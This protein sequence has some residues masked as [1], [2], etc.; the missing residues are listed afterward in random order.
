MPPG[1]QQLAAQP[2]AVQPRLRR[3]MWAAQRPCLCAACLPPPPR[4]LRRGQL[5]PAQPAQLPAVHSHLLRHRAAWLWRRPARTAAAGGTAGSR[6][7][8]ALGPCPPP[9]AAAPGAAAPAAPRTA[10]GAVHPAWKR[11]Q[12]SWEVVCATEYAAVGRLQPCSS[13]SHHIRETSRA[14]EPRQLCS[15]PNH[16]ATESCGSHQL[17]AAWRHVSS[18]A[19]E[20]AATTRSS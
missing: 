9:T 2:P 16:W 5:A 12:P 6:V 14:A 18:G 1:R 11:R 4:L 3:Q 19:V 10:W 15:R 17:T 13:A 7:Q 20:D 8:P